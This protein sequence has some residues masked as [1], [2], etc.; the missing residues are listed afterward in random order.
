MALAAAVVAGWG[1]AVPAVVAGPPRPAEAFEAVPVGARQPERTGRLIVAPRPGAG[2]PAADLLARHAIQA[3]PEV[4]EAVIRV[5][6]GEDEVAWAAALRATGDFRYVEPDWRVF[7]A[8]IPNDPIFAAQWHHQTIDAPGAWDLETGDGSIIVAIVDSGIDLDH[9]DLA[10]RLVPGYNA[11]DDL[12]QVDGGAVDGL[13]DHGTM[14]AGIVGAIGDNGVGV[15][16]VAWDV[17]LM[18]VRVS[19]L[20]NDSAFISDLNQGARWA[21]D[22]GA[23]IINVSFSSVSTQSVQTTGAYIREAGGTYV[24]SAGN[25]GVSLGVADHPDVTIVGA[26]DQS[27]ERA[28]FSN[29][30]PPIDVVAPGVGIET[31]AIG[32]Y[33]PNNGTS[34]AAPMAAGLLALI[35]SVDPEF[36]P[37]DAEAILGATAFDLGDPGEDGVFGAGR[38]DAAAAVALA[39]AA[40][41]GDVAPIASPDDVIALDPG[42]IEIDVLANDVE[43]DGDELE[44]GA[45]PATLP[46]GAVVT[47][48]GG[49]LTVTP[50]DGW[51]GTES[52]VYEARDSQGAVDAATV[53]LGVAFTPEFAAPIMVDTTGIGA[54]NR[55]GAGDFD[56]DGDLDLVGVHGSTFQSLEFYRNDGALAFTPSGPHSIDA[57][58]SPRILVTDLDGD[59]LDDLVHVHQLSDL[60]GITRTV[61]SFAFADTIWASIDDPISIAMIDANGDDR[62]DLLIGRGGFPSG[63]EIHVQD[64]TGTFTPALVHL[65]DVIGPASTVAAADMDGD[66]DED[67][68]VGTGGFHVHV[69][70]LEDLSVTAV[71]TLSISAGTAELIVKDVDGDGDVD[72]VCLAPFGLQGG[73]VVLRN[74]G[75]GT[76]VASD[77]IPATGSAPRGLAV[78][79]ADV[80]GDLDVLMGDL[81][82][83]HV[84]VSPGVDP[85]VFVG[86][87][88]T[89]DPLGGGVNDIAVADFDGDGDADVVA[90]IVHF[91]S[92]RVAVLENLTDPVRCLGD[93]DGDRSV[94][95]A[96]LLAIVANWG[97]CPGCPSD[98]DGNGAVDLDDLLI[99]LAAFGP[100]G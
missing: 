69:L 25:S 26:T 63:V 50:V 78:L 57:F 17:S 87:S 15:T 62:P 76:L 59:G 77:L 31:T 80:D 86:V 84:A 96:D 21:A 1:I 73:A 38:I 5:P 49:V 85:G 67:I 43:L 65:Q 34:F 4:G 54:A 7:A 24:W 83:Q 99:V 56:G 92:R 10:A 93:V 79:D 12:A 14:V 61:D 18:P 97:A 45:Y 40:R 39:V 47:E 8:A 42:P 3:H 27:D 52:F 20:P 91:G 19:N 70:L 100:C 2:R 16:G 89:S 82:S 90:P 71:S 81:V 72:A 28:W 22:H 37:I 53:T 75:A 41:D 64:E 13:T 74:D 51:E 6:A 60:L 94:D 58:D 88:G 55:I 95:F 66:G 9:P 46:S 36:D 35:L 98:V 30:G 44:I 23:R 29:F 48:S 32:G 11:V 33:A 68:I